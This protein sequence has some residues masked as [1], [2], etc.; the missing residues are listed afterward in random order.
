LPKVEEASLKAEIELTMGWIE[1][2]PNEGGGVL[3]ILAFAA[4]RAG[5]PPPHAGGGD[6]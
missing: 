3:A 5:A 2:G 6:A 4:C 1:I